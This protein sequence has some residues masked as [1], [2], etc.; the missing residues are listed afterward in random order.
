MEVKY[1]FMFTAARPRLWKEHAMR[2]LLKKT[3]ILLTLIAMAG[4]AAKPGA[5]PT[6][7]GAVSGPMPLATTH[8]GSPASPETAL[9]MISLDSLLGFVEDLTAIQPYSGWRNSASSGERE[10]LDYAAENT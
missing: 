8:T 10:A 5:L 3:L 4:C 2:N 6:P 7:T 1:A 9:E